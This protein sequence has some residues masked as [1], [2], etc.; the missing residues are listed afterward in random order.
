M[1]IIEKRSAI[2]KKKKKW[3]GMSEEGRYIVRQM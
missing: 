1:M 2:G 3:I